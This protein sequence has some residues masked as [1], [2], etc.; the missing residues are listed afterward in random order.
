[1]LLTFERHKRITHQSEYQLLFKSPDIR[2]RTGKILLLAKKNDLMLP[3]L[4][5]VVAK[6]HL[7]KSVE[8]NQCKRLIRES[9]RK[10]QVF[11]PNYDMIAI[12]V[13]G[14]NQATRV[15]I[16]QWLDELWVRLSKHA[17]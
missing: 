13:S 15:D 14:I 17:N 5:L 11:L 10:Q 12:V 9:F 4:G 7:R 16:N 1:L 6:K 2:L 3:R 8:R